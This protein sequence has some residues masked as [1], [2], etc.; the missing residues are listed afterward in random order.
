MSRLLWLSTAVDFFVAK[1]LHTAEGNRRLLLLASLGTNLG[2]LAAFKYAGFF[3]AQF[4]LESEVPDF[5]LPVG[6]SFYTFQTMSYTIDVYRGTRAPTSS[7]LD[8]SLYVTFFPQLV[9]GPIVRS[10]AFLP[11]A[12]DPPARPLAERLELG[13]SLMAL[14]LFEKTVLG[15]WVF[16]ARRRESLRSTTRALVRRRVGGHAR[17]HRADL[18]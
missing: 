13:L 6:I 14:G 2:L 4:G 9:A 17:V 1:K 12:E 10:D 3:A 15:R 8:F 16:R 5:I 18:L 11:Q 7:L